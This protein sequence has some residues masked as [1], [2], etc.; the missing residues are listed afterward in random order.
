LK[1]W[2]PFRQGGLAISQQNEFFCFNSR[3]APMIRVI[4]VT[5]GARA[6]EQTG[7]EALSACD[8]AEFCWVDL[9]EFDDSELHLLQ[10]RF[11][12]H[13]L[14]IEDCAGP[15]SRP[16]LSNYDN[17]LFLIM[18]SM[19]VAADSRIPKFDELGIFLGERFLL[20]VHRKPLA[21][22]DSV[23]KRTLGDPRL[24]NR[25]A[26]YVCYLIVDE[27]MEETFP[28]LEHLSQALLQVERT[29]VTRPDGSEL[30]KMLNIKRG[31]VA[32]RRAVAAERDMLAMA[33]RM[34]TPLIGDKNAIYF[35]DCYDHLLRIF[36]DINLERDMLG[37]AMD[38]YLSSVSNRL[39]II[40]KQLTI[41]TAIFMPPTFITSFFGQNF[42]ALPF[43]S[44]SLFIAEVITCVS[45]PAI[46]LYWFYRSG[47]MRSSGG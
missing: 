28:V 19:S 7:P 21:A 15:R 38:A 42:T 36:E 33:V 23:W 29:I 34:D 2:P 9:Q 41:L 43:D 6:V 13:Q 32:V 17:Y 31:L 14:A 26:D 4:R 16:K 27:L 25:G 5:G 8:G 30:A 1:P 39:G 18:D 35:R 10:Q 3:E 46:M 37:N 40:M 47:W 11:A 22:I 20:T 44:H 45:L 12:L 24:I